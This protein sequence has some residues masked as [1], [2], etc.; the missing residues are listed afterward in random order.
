MFSYRRV[1]SLVDEETTLIQATILSAGGRILRCSQNVQSGSCS[2]SEQTPKFRPSITLAA[3][4]ADLFT[5][6]TDHAPLRRFRTVVLRRWKMSARRPRV[7]VH[8]VVPL[9]SAVRWLQSHHRPPVG[10]RHTR[11]DSDGD[12]GNTVPD[13][14]CRYAIDFAQSLDFSRGALSCAVCVHAGLPISG[15]PD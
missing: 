10:L 4:H 14:G 11:S 1:Y 12:I 6:P 2:I 13:C 3:S 15:E 5:G 9:Q 8:T 7:D